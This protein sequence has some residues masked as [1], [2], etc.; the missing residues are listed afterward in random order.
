MVVGAAVRVDLLLPRHQVE[1]EAAGLVAL[2]LTPTQTALVTLTA[3]ISGTALAATPRSRGLC[4]AAACLQITHDTCPL[5]QTA[6]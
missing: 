5:A 1:V 2:L 3:V 4:Q 6:S